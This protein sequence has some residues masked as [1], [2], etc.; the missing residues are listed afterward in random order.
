MRT[1]QL[2]CTFNFPVSNMLS[3]RQM[4]CMQY[5]TVSL[6]LLYYSYVVTECVSLFRTYIN[7]IRFLF[8]YTY[9]KYETTQK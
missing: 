3:H 2:A 1:L 7:N 6:L 9:L 5:I 4:H 8:L